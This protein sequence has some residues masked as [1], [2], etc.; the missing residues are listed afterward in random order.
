[1]YNRSVIDT[2]KSQYIQIKSKD[3][4][5]LYIKSEAGQLCHLSYT[6]ESCLNDISEALLGN[7]IITSQIIKNSTSLLTNIV[8]EEWSNIWDGPEIP[9][10]YLKCLAKKIN[11]MMNYI[12][13]ALSNNVLETSSVNLSE[14]LH[15]E[16]FINALRQKSARSMKVPID[17]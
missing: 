10:S 7:G 6:V 4:I 3:P 17:E 9:N 1:M 2:I 13:G 12:K 5:S 15:P 14:F 8:P 16:A 11:G